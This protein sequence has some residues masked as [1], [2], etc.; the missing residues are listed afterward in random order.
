M[1]SE[2]WIFV[3]MIIGSGLFYGSTLW[4]KRAN[5]SAAIKDIRNGK[6]IFLTFNYT[7]EEWKYA[8]ENYFDLKFRNGDNGKVCFTPQYIYLSNG[9]SYILHELIGQNR[10]A[11]HL[12]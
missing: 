1:P 4:L 7:S 11:K 6:G 3:T 5:R 8:T 10:F 12:T 9:R 2:L